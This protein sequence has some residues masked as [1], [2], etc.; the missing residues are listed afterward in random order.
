MEKSFIDHV[1]FSLVK[2]YFWTGGKKLIEV[3]EISFNNGKTQ[4]VFIFE[5]DSMFPAQ[6]LPLLNVIVMKRNLFSDYSENVQ[7]FILEHEYAHGKHYLIT[8]LLLIPLSFGLLGVSFGFLGT[9]T[10]LFFG[11]ILNRPYILYEGMFLG[12]GFLSSALLVIL[13]SWPMEFY[14]DY[15]AFKAIGLEN[16]ENAYTEMKSK[17][18]KRNLL[19]KMISRLTHPPMKWNLWAYKKLSK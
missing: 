12:I 15:N 3:K 8:S 4:T 10:Y 5:G 16:A 13:I 9:L 18:D 19:K 14:A 2:L 17:P 1:R 7:K 6:N 11:L